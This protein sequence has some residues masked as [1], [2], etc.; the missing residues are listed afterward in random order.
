MCGSF[1]VWSMLIPA[2][3]DFAKQQVSILQRML[4]LSTKNTNSKY[5][6]NTKQ[7]PRQQNRNET[8]AFNI[9]SFRI[10]S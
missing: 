1:S 7:N 4:V 5:N 8:A 9:P 10:S 6:K 3:S 2:P